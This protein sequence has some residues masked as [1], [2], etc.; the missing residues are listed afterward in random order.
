MDWVRF[1]EATVVLSGAGGLFELFLYFGFVHLRLERAFGV[2]PAVVLTAILYV[3]WHVGT[4][5]P[6]EPDPLFGAVKLLGVGLFYQSVFSLTRNVLIIWPF[7]HAVGVMIDF[8]VNLET[9]DRP[10]IELPW[11]LASIAAMLATVGAIVLRRR[12]LREDS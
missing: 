4:Q 10:A 6:L 11:A 8:A 12:A 3:P 2:L 7:F 5:L 1:A 9:L